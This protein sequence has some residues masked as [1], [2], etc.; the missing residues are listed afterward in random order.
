MLSID[1]HTPVAASSQQQCPDRGT[2]HSRDKQT[3]RKPA[4]VHASSFRVAA[5]QRQAEQGEPNL[6]AA[7]KGQVVK[8]ASAGRLIPVALAAD[9]PGCCLQDVL[10]TALGCDQG[11]EGQ[12]ARQAKGKACRPERQ[13]TGAAGSACCNTQTSRQQDKTR[14]PAGVLGSISIQG[15]CSSHAC[16][17]EDPGPRCIG[18][19]CRPVK[20]VVKGSNKGKPTVLKL[21]TGQAH[22]AASVQMEAQ[23]AVSFQA[24]GTSCSQVCQPCI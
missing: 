23:T 22:A 9:T 21:R 20:Q 1:C 4:S 11:A 16:K 15:L 5:L 2:L 13:S 14:A 3:G 19:L 10:G 8:P 17:E 12:E 7:A 6:H 18:G 24:E